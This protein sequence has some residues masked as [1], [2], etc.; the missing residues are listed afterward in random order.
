[1]L[2]DGV[3]CRAVR[4]IG[5]LRALH[6][7]VAGTAQRVIAHL[8]GARERYGGLR[9]LD[10][11]RGLRDLRPC[12]GSARD[13]L[14]YAA[15][16][17]GCCLF[18]AERGFVDLTRQYG[19]CRLRLAR[20]IL[21]CFYCR[22]G[23]GSLG[24]RLRIIELDENLADAND[25]AFSH[26]DPRYA[27][28]NLRTKIILVPFES[29]AHRDLG[30]RRSR[31]KHVHDEDRDEPKHNQNCHAGEHN[32]PGNP[33]TRSCGRWRGWGRRRFGR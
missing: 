22:C 31:P 5:L 4:R 8:I 15:T 19:Q 13:C 9:L 12:G 3:G 17:I 1:L 26:G 11:S 24:T 33:P 2:G 18:A 21:C 20:T 14:R 27:S 32:R 28:P 16:R 23:C 6:G 29:S 10:Y 30:R 25:R 7:D